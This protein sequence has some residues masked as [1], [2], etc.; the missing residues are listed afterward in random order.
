LKNK[1]VKIIKIALGSTIAILIAYLLNLHYA[2]AAGVI[3][4]LSIQDTK[5]ATLQMAI[6]RVLAFIVTCGIAYIVFYLFS[7]T[8]IAYGIYLLMFS[9]FCIFFK[10]QDALAMNAVLATHFLLEKSMGIEIITN[11]ALLLLI[12]AGIGILI[13]L[14]IPNNVRQIRK[15]QKKIEECLKLALTELAQRIEQTEK[16]EEPKACK[17]TLK[18]NIKEG[19]EHA[20]VN[21][22]NTFFQDSRYFIMYMGMRKQQ[23][24]VLKEM[25][26]KADTLTM[27]T[28]QSHVIADFIRMVEETLS[29]SNN[30]ER[31]LL[32]EKLLMERCQ[33]DLLPVTREE[34]ETRAILYILLMNFR[35]FLTIKK[36]F[37]DSLSNGQKEKFW[38]EE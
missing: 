37:V 23:S 22:H 29:E 7:F 9:F 1:I 2:V 15:T 35:M 3:A 32:E 31:L 34:F 4:L 14:Y 30:T 10:M 12:G 27:V 5:K 25:Y 28:T 11:E 16:I 8:P 38:N 19:M 33:N 13:N 26:E 18:K 36:D 17:V 21:M 24:Y 6:K 20:Y